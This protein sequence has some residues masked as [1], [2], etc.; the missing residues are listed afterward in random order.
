MSLNS[1]SDQYNFFS[2][3]GVFIIFWNGVDEQKL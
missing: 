2:R 1:A 3:K